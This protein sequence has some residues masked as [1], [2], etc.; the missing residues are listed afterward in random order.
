MRT[1]KYSSLLY[2]MELQIGPQGP[3]PVFGKLLKLE[4]IYRDLIR[5]IY[6]FIFV[7]EFIISE[8]KLKIQET[9]FVIDNIFLSNNYLKWV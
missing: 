1:T 8:V 6:I 3:V 4:G 5:E 2:K 9:Y 7:Y